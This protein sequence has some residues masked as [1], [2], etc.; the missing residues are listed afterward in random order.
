MNS[1]PAL[2]VQKTVDY[3]KHNSFPTDE[4]KDQ[5]MSNSDKHSQEGN[6]KNTSSDMQS[7]YG[8]R[9]N[10]RQEVISPMQTA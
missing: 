7:L 2:N 4:M 10:I 1:G 5:A 9:S 6:L 8:D 3:V